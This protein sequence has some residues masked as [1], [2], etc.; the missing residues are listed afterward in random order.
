MNHLD[1]TQ[2]LNP[3]TNLEIF[4]DQIMQNYPG[5]IFITD[6][7]GKLV[8]VTDSIEQMLGKKPEWFIGK[9]VDDIINEGIVKETSTQEA[10]S[11]GKTNIKY[12]TSTTGA[13][14]LIISRPI[15]DD[16]GKLKYIFS[17]AALQ[18]E[19]EKANRYFQ[20]ERKKYENVIQYLS[21]INDNN[22]QIIAESSSMKHLLSVTR[23][24]AETNSTIMISGESGTGKEVIA[25]FIHQCS[26]RS[27]KPFIPVNCAAIPAELA[28]AQFFGY[29]KGAFTG[30]SK[31]GKA[32]LFE[33][34]DKG[35]IF[36]D[37]IGE[38]PLLIQSKLL[39]VLETGTV[40]RVGGGEKT[41]QVDVRIIAATNRN[42][43][44]EVKN[45]HF[46]EDLYYRLNVFPITIAPLR[47]R[48]EDIEALAQL[49]LQKYN[50]QYHTS[51]VFDPMTID[52]FKQYKWPGNVRELRNIVERL[53]LLSN[54]ILSPE[55][56][57]NS[58]TPKTEWTASKETT[59]FKATEHKK[60][61]DRLKEYEADCIRQAL[62][63]HHGDVPGAAMELEIPVSTLYQKIRNYGLNIKN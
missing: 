23:R 32:G 48:P 10:I 29:E 45:G 2:T 49:F 31:E 8:Y 3:Q 56:L 22:T 34:A 47:E 9:T 25:H 43:F 42:L 39:R 28:E 16:K 41:K 27:D 58:F 14:M 18:Y 24:I 15:F 35:T 63:H 52:I 44:Q 40:S 53:A 5:S 33:F 12:L 50:R 19:Y 61:K 46:R 11:S 60:L 36:L 30:A 55:H 62:I 7:N 21:E 20:K 13:V 4:F 38:L 57:D 17:Y 59:V 37:E 6:G 51:K 1:I 26:N 54:G